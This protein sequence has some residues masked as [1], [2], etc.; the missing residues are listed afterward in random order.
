[1][2][3]K[4][5]PRLQNLA[6][7]LLAWE[8]RPGKGSA[9]KGR[10]PGRVAGFRVCAK[11]RGPMVRLTGVGGFRALLSRALALA[12]QQVAWLDTLEVQADGGL[13]G[14]DRL[15]AELPAAEL[16]RGEIAVVCQ[17]LGLLDTFIGS[18]LTL[19]LLQDAWPGRDFS[20]FEASP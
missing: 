7:R 17:L 5:S 20:E 19:G 14:L 10:G 13:A 3:A 9:G 15:S 12:S 6:E 1:M 4:A 8:A 2:P 11:L 18:T 16:S